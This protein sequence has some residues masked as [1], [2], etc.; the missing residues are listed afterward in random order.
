MVTQP[1]LWK[2]CLGKWTKETIFT[3]LKGNKAFKATSEEKLRAII[4]EIVRKPFQRGEIIFDSAI[5]EKKCALYIIES[6]E[7]EL[8]F[9]G[10]SQYL[11]GEKVWRLYG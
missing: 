10:G 6:G 8:C 4:S 5:I 3:V 2:K 11:L 1:G 9:D 7:A